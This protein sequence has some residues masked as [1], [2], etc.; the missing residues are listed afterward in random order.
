MELYS[1]S[2]KYISPSDTQFKCLLEKC[3]S[4]TAPV[5]HSTHFVIS[6]IRFYSFSNTS[7]PLMVIIRK[8]TLK[9]TGITNSNCTPYVHSPVIC[10]L[11][12]RSHDHH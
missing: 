5:H 11:T 8:I 6:D 2:M 3:M 4:L 9:F 7:Q 12:L 10:V 1:S